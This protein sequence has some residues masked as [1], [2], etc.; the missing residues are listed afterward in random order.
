LHPN[1]IPG[2]KAS[3]LCIRHVHILAS[4][5][6]HFLCSIV[7]RTDCPVWLETWRFVNNPRGNSRVP[8]SF[9][10][11]VLLLAQILHKPSRLAKIDVAIDGADEISPGLDC[12]KVCQMS[13]CIT[14]ICCRT[15][16]R[17]ALDI[18]PIAMFAQLSS[19]LS[20]YPCNTSR[21]M[22]TD[23]ITNID[24]SVGPCMTKGRRWLSCARE[25]HSLCR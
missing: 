20:P 18:N 16:L 15:R 10:R 12:I 3:P 21:K 22:F 8:C 1:I 5:F 17:S 11:I 14:M 4:H 9:V 19:M 25:D 13:E 23:S 6:S 24:L 7:A 2:S